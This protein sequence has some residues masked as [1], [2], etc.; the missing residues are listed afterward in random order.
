MRLL[1]IL[2]CSAHCFLYAQDLPEQIRS[3]HFSCHKAEN[4]IVSSKYDSGLELYLEA[5]KIDSVNLFARDIYNAFAC[6]V[7]LE[8]REIAYE[9]LEKLVY[10]GFSL[11]DTSSKVSKMLKKLKSQDKERFSTF[12]ELIYPKIRTHYESKI[13][14]KYREFVLNL[15]PRDQEYRKKPG[16]YKKYMNE[17]MHMDSLNCYEFIEW[18]QKEGFPNE[19]KIGIDKDFSSPYYIVVHHHAQ[20]F[21]RNK[22]RDLF[23]NILSDALQQGEVLPSDY[24]AY[25][26][27]L[28]D[29]SMPKYG[30]NYYL[31]K[32]GNKKGWYYYNISTENERQI[33][34]NRFKIGLDSIRDYRSKLFFNSRNN[35]FYFRQYNNYQHLSLQQAK[36]FG[37]SISK[38]QTSL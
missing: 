37:K 18:I 36:K 27:L 17:I 1:L 33:E 34:S 29:K 35:F 20:Q 21:S 23:S 15:E 2:F 24:V 25:V 14:Q 7:L 12:S 31:I 13:N 19:N 6:A 11:T 30:T 38:Y 16:G 3:Y 26:D 9:L 8:K 28:N 32:L 10:K 22:K 4:E 5:F